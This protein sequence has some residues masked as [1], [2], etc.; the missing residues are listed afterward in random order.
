MNPLIMG[1]I[2]EVTEVIN[3]V[4]MEVIQKPYFYMIFQKLLM[5]Y[6]LP[7]HMYINQKMQLQKTEVIP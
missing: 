7:I 4:R 2:M 6:F 3:K 1:L 5:M